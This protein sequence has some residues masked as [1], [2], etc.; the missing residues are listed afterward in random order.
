M[1]F[2]SA[3]RLRQKGSRRLAGAHQARPP[4]RRR[5][6]DGANGQGAGLAINANAAWAAKNSEDPLIVRFYRYILIFV[7]FQWDDDNVGHIAE[8]GIR[9]DEAEYVVE[10]AAPPFPRSAGNGKFMVWGR[11]PDSSFLQVGF[12]HLP[13]DRVEIDRLEPHEV[14]D[15]QA[16]AQVLYVFHAMPMTEEQKRQ[17]RKL[18]GRS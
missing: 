16:G 11:A 12:V 1:T 15:F 10:H 14:L 4:L 6:V 17:Y 8:H 18:K 5:H 2:R 7:I 9:R 13:D 3:P